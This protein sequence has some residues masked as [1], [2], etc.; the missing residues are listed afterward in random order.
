MVELFCKTDGLVHRNF[1]DGLACALFDLVSK[2]TMDEY[3]S[4]LKDKRH[5]KSRILM[6]GKLR[7]SKQPEII[8]LVD[9]LFEDPDLRTE[10]GSWKRFKGRK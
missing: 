8:A 9:E 2:K 6:V 10:I 3:I 4:L 1:K 7:R 5:G